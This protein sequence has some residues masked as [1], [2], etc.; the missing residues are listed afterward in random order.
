M[1][2]T[3]SSGKWDY[4]ADLE[5]TRYGDEP[6]Y[7]KAAKFLDGCGPVV[8]DW[9]CGTAYAR[10]FFKKSRYI[11][12]DGSPS[13][14]TEVVADLRQ[15]RSTPDGILMRHILEHNVEWREILRNALQSFKHRM[16]LVFFLPPDD[17]PTRP[18]RG[19]P[20]DP[21]IGV[22]NLVIARSEI[23]EALG[24]LRVGEERICGLENTALSTEEVIYY[25]E[26]TGE[27]REEGRP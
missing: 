18:Y 12:V 24:T 5:S 22:P 10:K 23:L 4:S 7:Q 11:G 27:P 17:G 6:S 2:H 1:E 26:K 8:E 3:T 15:Y 13:R 16:A 21:F 19:E 25:L 20:V 9:G 14:M